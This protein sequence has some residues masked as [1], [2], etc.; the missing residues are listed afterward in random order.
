MMTE[1]DREREE[2]VEEDREV[3]GRQR[4]SDER[5]ER[6]KRLETEKRLKREESKGTPSS[7]VILQNTDKQKLVSCARLPGSFFSN[8]REFRLAAS[9]EPAA[10]QL[11]SSVSAVFFAPRVCG[12]F[13]SVQTPLK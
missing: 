9:F 3:K 10:Y 12:P 4:E 6:C 8:H 1:R 2:K 5:R 7:A 11:S 13:Q